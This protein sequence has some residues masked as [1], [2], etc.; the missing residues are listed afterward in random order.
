[1]QFCLDNLANVKC[2]NLRKVYE[3]I[4]RIFGLDIILR[5]LGFFLTEG[6]VSPQAA[7]IA[8]GTL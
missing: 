7:K 5:D 8:Q 4:Y 3:T 1:M 6:V 2:Q